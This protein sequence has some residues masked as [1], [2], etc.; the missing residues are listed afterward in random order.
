MKLLDKGRHSRNCYHNLT[1]KNTEGDRGVWPY[2]VI[3]RQRLS[4]NFKDISG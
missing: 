1:Y 2:S 3:R 4:S